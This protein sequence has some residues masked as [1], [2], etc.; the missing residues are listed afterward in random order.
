MSVTEMII[1]YDWYRKIF[2]YIY[3]QAHS[4]DASVR[5]IYRVLTD[6]DVVL[7]RLEHIQNINPV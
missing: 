3:I 4:R 2:L 7:Q 1:I 6:S 5:V